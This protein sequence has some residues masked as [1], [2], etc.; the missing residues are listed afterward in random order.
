M[1]AKNASSA[2]SRPPQSNVTQQSG[3]A[4]QA[5]PS[6]ELHDAVAD[7]PTIPAVAST[8]AVSPSTTSLPDAMIPRAGRWTRFWLFVCYTVRCETG[9]DRDDDEV[10]S[11]VWYTT[12]RITCLE[13]NRHKHNNYTSCLSSGSRACSRRNADEVNLT[14][15]LGHV[16]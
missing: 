10:Q 11:P 13:T 3:G 9:I 4:A 14:L 2:N 1:A 8:S 7:S 6:S 15:S 12:M 5:Q 16:V